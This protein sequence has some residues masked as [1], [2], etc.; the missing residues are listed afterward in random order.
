MRASALLSLLVLAL[1]TATFAA[2]SQAAAGS[3]AQTNELRATLFGAADTALAAANAAQAS[4]LAPAAYADGAEAYRRADARLADEGDLEAIR[5]DLASARAQFEQAAEA[6]ATAR[7]VLAAPLKA[8]NDAENAE[9]GRYAPELWQRGIETFNDAAIALE[10]GR[11]GRA[12]RLGQDALEQLKDAELAAIKA[13][14]LNETRSLLEQAD[15]LRAKRYA[16]QS[17]ERAGKLLEQAEAL[18][19]S[20]RYDT[21]QPR[22]LAQLA[23]HTARH[24]I[25]VATLEQQIR[26]DDTNL[27]QILLGWEASLNEIADQL[28]VPVYFDNG[29]KDAVALIRQSLRTLQDDLDFLQQAVDDR[30]ARIAALETELGG[31]SV[32]L[33]RLNETVARQERQRERISRV[34]SLFDPEQVQVLRSGDG[35]IL[36]LIG[37]NF[38]SGSASL[39]PRQIELLDRVQRAIALFPEANMVV[40]GHTDSFGSELANQSL[41]QARAD[42][43]V[44][45]LL[46]NSPVSPTSVTALGYGESRPVANNETPEGRARNRRIDIVI[47]PKW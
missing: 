19:N 21:D 30:D 10:R 9:A 38:A 8:R 47:Y 20:D 24:A 29:E 17:F 32:S 39:D 40:E 11:E 44:Q 46:A 45:Y 34:E 6:S 5:R 33:A 23:E 16:P 36:R 12:E 27:E 43:V 31:K 35:I 15:D 25:Y 28:D 41:S 22:N 7:T 14:Y 13:N 4:I 2:S 18:L 26:K 42:S 3:S 1:A 37:L